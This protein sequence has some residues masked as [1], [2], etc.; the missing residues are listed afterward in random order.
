MPKFISLPVEVEAIQFTGKNGAEVAEW[1]NERADF[2][3]AHPELPDDTAITWFIT[4]GMSASTGSQAWRYVKDGA[5]WPDSVKA[6]VFNFLSGVWLPVH[7]FE[8]VV[9]DSEG[10]FYPCAVKVFLARYKPA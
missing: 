1:V 9:Q 5:K 10:A 7:N 2:S 6:S 8:F 4:R 3:R